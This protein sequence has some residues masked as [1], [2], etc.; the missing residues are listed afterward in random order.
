MKRM[1]RRHLAL[2]RFIADYE[3][4]PTFGH[5]ILN[6]RRSQLARLLQQ[7][8]RRTILVETKSAIL[9]TAR[10]LWT[11]VLAALGVVLFIAVDRLRGWL[12]WIVVIGLLLFM[13]GYVAA[14]LW[15]AAYWWNEVDDRDDSRP[16]DD[17][18]V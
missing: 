11:V 14:T 7:L 18:T 3:C 1:N 16:P 13:V 2:A 12:Q 5:T 4:D 17:I 10:V 15:D 8:P 6:V 9:K